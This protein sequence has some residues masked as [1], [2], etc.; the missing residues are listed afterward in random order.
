MGYAVLAVIAG[1]LAVWFIGTGVRQWRGHG[2][3]L[4]SWMRTGG[5]FDAHAK[6]A[7]DRGSLVLGAGMACFTVL[8]GGTALFGLPSKSTPAAGMAVY[9][10]AIAGIIVTAALFISIYNYNW[11]KFL[12]PPHL[13]DQVGV[14]AGRRQ[15]RA[16][17]RAARTARQPP[18]PGQPQRPPRAG[19]RKHR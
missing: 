1:L 19:G 5:M 16:A 12:V 15:D 10:V 9:G 6:A 3:P 14:T 8:L 17:R 7:Y 4:S 13:R 2:R 11:P 18:Q